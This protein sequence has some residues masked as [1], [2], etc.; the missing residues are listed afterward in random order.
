MIAQY[1]C[2]SLL[3]VVI[4]N[5]PMIQNILEPEVFNSSRIGCEELFYDA[6]RCSCGCELWIKALAEHVSGMRAR[7]GC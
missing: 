2:F 1:L 6:K 4:F 3:L 7:V 5:N